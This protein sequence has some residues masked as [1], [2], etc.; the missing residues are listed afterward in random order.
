MRCRRA[1]R[2]S[3]LTAEKPTEL[4]R[5]A[6][7][8]VGNR[9]LRTLYQPA[10]TGPQVALALGTQMREQDFEQAPPGADALENEVLAHGGYA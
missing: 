1:R 2:L 8:T 3:A 7:V 10:K 5:S 4:R 6:W 9:V